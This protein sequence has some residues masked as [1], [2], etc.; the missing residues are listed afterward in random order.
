MELTGPFVNELLGF[1]AQFVRGSMLA[2]SLEAPRLKLYHHKN[3]LL[4]ATKNMKTE[5]KL[6]SSGQIARLSKVT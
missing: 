1:G 4:D 6:K 3:Q 2:I 5:S